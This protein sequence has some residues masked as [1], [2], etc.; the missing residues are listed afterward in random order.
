MAVLRRTPRRVHGV[1]NRRAGVLPW[2]AVHALLLHRLPRGGLASHGADNPGLKAC[3]A[4]NRARDVVFVVDV[5]NTVKG[6]GQVDDFLD[7]VRVSIKLLGT[8]HTANVSANGWLSQ[9]ANVP[10]VPASV[11][12][13]CVAGGVGRVGVGLL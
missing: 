1:N 10:R 13:L 12:S 5:S 7:L 4:N 3:L 11:L 9:K 2:L 8:G 6:A